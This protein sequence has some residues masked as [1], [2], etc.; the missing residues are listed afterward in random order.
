[1]DQYQEKVGRQ[2]GDV[3]WMFHFTV[4]T[5]VRENQLVQ[6]WICVC[7]CVCVKMPSGG[8]VLITRAAQVDMNL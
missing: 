1:M 4:F 6:L 8:G 7:V 3:Q 5:Q 2:L